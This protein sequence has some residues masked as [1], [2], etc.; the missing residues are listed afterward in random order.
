MIN[1]D[2]VKTMDM[3]KELQSRLES[4][5]E[6]KIEQQLYSSNNLF[7]I[8][9]LMV[10]DGT[11]YRRCVALALPSGFEAITLLKRVLR[12]LASNTD[13]RIVIHELVKVDDRS[14][15]DIVKGTLVKVV[16]RHTRADMYC[17]W[18]PEYEYWSW[19]INDGDVYVV[20]QL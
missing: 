2:M 7:E 8:S 15:K 3:I 6:I 18:T 4:N 11:E 16:N 9:L 12:G 1:Y 10:H 14:L 13:K 5:C 19:V 17:R 20:N